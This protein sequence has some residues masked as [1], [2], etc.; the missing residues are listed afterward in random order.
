MQ[1]GAWVGES[2]V[3]KLNE[4]GNTNNEPEMVVKAMDPDTWLDKFEVY[5]YGP[6]EYKTP[7]LH[8]WPP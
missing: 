5:L 3:A 6:Y 4:A 1:M 8:L 7:G 2:L